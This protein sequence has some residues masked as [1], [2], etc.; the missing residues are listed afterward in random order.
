MR[1]KSMENEVLSIAD[2]R[3]KVTYDLALARGAVRAMDFRQ[4]KTGP[5]DFGVMTYHPAFLNT[6]SCQMEKRTSKRVGE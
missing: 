1:G 4:I 2:K 3:T 5:E 6:A